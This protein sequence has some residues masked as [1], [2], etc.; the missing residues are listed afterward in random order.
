VKAIEWVQIDRH[1]YN[2]VHVHGIVFDAVT[3]CRGHE[4]ATCPKE[5]WRR[6]N[7]QNENVCAFSKD[8]ITHTK[9]DAVYASKKGETFHEDG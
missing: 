1:I 5:M 4:V 9:N 7:P 2:D 3:K 6:V 8:E